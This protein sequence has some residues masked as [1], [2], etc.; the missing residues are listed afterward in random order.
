VAS[1]LQIHPK[2]PDIPSL[3]GNIVTNTESYKRVIVTICG[4]KSLA[5]TTRE[6]VTAFVGAEAKGATV[7]LHCKEFGW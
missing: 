3:I 1:S 5:V 6:A 4:P 7:W 2:R